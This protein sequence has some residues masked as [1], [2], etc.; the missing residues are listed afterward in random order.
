MSTSTPA[1]YEGDAAK[2]RVGD[3]R[4]HLQDNPL[5]HILVANAECTLLI[6]IHEKEPHG[7]RV[8]MTALANKPIAPD[9]VAVAAYVVKDSLLSLEIPVAPGR[10]R[11][12]TH[13]A[14]RIDHGPS[15]T[16]EIPSL[17]WL[18]RAHSQQ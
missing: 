3:N 13:G 17:I 4:F 12:R 1:A 11:A 16:T 8:Q 10:V 6:A 5:A 18:K 9:V 15:R 14:S 2:A 7:Q